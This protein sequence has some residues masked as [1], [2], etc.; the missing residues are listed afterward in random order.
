MVVDTKQKTDAAK[1]II[2]SIYASQRAL[3]ALA[4]EYKWAGL[5]NLLG[6]FGEFIAINHYGLDKAPASSEGYDAITKDGKT[7]QIKTNHAAQQIGF[8][9]KADLI[10]VIHV[11]EDGSWDEIYFGDHELVEKNS[12]FSARDNKR[13]I[14]ITK[15]KTL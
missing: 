2:A 14:S 11:E 1:G 8:R 3:K 12:T 15:L 9:G 7:V 13:M 4:P 5:G 6:D 10:L